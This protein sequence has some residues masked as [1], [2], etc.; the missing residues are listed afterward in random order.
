MKGTH[1]ESIYNVICA[2]KEIRTKYMG[3]RKRMTTFTWGGIMI[4]EGFS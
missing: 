3:I 2:L 4:E 1:K